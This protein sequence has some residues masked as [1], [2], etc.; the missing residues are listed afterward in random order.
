M[1]RFLII[2]VVFGALLGVGSGAQAQQVVG[3][4]YTCDASY[5]SYTACARI[6]NNVETFTAPGKLA[7]VRPLVSIIR[8]TQTCMWFNGAPV[9]NATSPIVSSATGS[10]QF[11]GALCA[12]GTFVYGM[13]LQ[14]GAPN[15]QATVGLRVDK[16]ERVSPRIWRRFAVS[17]RL[18]VRRG[19]QQ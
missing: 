17:E 6:T 10:S 3:A 1:R 15:Y 18:R 11:N 12:G 16:R 9:W 7:K 5:W 8:N 19:Q 14:D 2:A 4:S 13:R